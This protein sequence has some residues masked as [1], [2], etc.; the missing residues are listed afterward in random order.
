MSSYYS[1]NQRVW[2]CS[3]AV[4]ANYCR[5]RL[6]NS[7]PTSAMQFHCP[8]PYFYLNC[9]T[10]CRTRL[11]M[12]PCSHSRACPL[13]IHLTF[14]FCS[15]VCYCL[16]VCQSKCRGIH[17]A[18][19]HKL[20]WWIRG[21]YWLVR[22]PNWSSPSNLVWAVVV[23]SVLSVWSPGKCPRRTTVHQLIELFLTCQ[24]SLFWTVWCAHWF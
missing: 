13:T 6:S 2:P 23:G 20:I 3:G 15:L 17:P 8:P 21:P 19:W 4:V 11:W 14:V 10:V 16:T 12:F 9:Q 24:N 22:H 7:V 1:S 18:I 5:C